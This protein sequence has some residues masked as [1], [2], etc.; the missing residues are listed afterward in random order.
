MEKA[1]DEIRIYQRRDS[2]KGEAHELKIQ[3]FTCN[4]HFSQKYK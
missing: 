3:L 4:G 2:I 1:T